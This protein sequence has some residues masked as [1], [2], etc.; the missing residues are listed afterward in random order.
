MLFYSSNQIDSLNSVISGLYPKGMYDLSGSHDG[1]KLDHYSRIHSPLRRAG[2]LLMDYAQSICLD[3]EPTDQELSYLEEELNSKK[4]LLNQK[5]AK[6]SL[7]KNEIR[8]T[9]KRR[10]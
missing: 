7:F 3:Q 8:R 1:L 9:F 10:R 6:I 2:D 4:E 5:E